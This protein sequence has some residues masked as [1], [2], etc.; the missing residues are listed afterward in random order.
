MKFLIHFSIL[1]CNLYCLMYAWYKLE[2]KNFII[3]C[4]V[5]FPLIVFEIASIFFLIF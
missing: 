2:R 4:V 1:L 5:A 3:I